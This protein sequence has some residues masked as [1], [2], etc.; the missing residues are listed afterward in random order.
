MNYSAIKY[1]DIANGEGIRTSLFVSGCR[2]FCPGCFNKEAQNYNNG[3]EFDNNTIDMILDSIDDEY[4]DGIS[5]LGGEPMD[6]LN[7]IEV[8]KLCYKFRKRYGWTKSIWL[9]TG[10]SFEYLMLYH[11]EPYFQLLKR[12]DILVDGQFIESQKDISLKF[13][14]SKNQRVIDLRKTFETGKITIKEGYEV[15][16]MPTETKLEFLK[17]DK[18]VREIPGTIVCHFKRLDYIEKCIKDNKEYDPNIYLYEIV[19]VGK[20]TETNEKYVIYKAIYN[21]KEW[22]ISFGDIFCRPYD[23]FMS[24]VDVFKYPNAMQEFRFEPY[25][26]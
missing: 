2:H 12:I 18:D 16:N 14:G 19:G 23:M 10:Y 1:N 3:E 13:R 24:R 5:I 6:W 17:S 15:E 4:H 22:G 25:K 8:V 7:V 20:N 9:Y 21:H 11:E 26:F